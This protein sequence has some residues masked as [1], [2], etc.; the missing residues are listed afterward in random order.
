MNTFI[1]SIPIYIIIAIPKTRFISVHRGGFKSLQMH[2]KSRGSTD[3][4]KNNISII[5]KAHNSAK[6][7]YR[8]INVTSK[9]YLSLRSHVIY[10]ANI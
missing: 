8:K 7:D 5:D 2:L 10:T 9:T 4:Q 6:K 3:T 1:L